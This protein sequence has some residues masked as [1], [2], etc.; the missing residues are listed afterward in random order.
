MSGE[1]PASVIDDTARA[2]WVGHDG[3]RAATSGRAADP[4]P[5]VNGPS[6]GWS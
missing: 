1:I 6:L 5:Q 4:V 3:V 2:A